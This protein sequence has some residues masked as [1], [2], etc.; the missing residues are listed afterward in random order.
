MRDTDVYYALNERE[1]KGRPRDG[2][3]RNQG[4]K[5]KGSTQQQGKFSGVHAENTKLSIGQIIAHMFEKAINVQYCDFLGK[6]SKAHLE[7][8]FCGSED[9]LYSRDMHI[10]KYWM[11]LEPS[12]QDEFW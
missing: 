9:H 12:E 4:P 1:C 5:P 11:K 3:Y 2:P 10:A 8:F 6:L 7:F